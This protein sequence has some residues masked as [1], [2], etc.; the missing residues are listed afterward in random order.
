MN[1]FSLT[2]KW[3]ENLPKGQ[4]FTNKQE[5]PLYHTA[6]IHTIVQRITCNSK[7]YRVFLRN[8]PPT[9]SRNWSK[10]LRVTENCIWAT[11]PGKIRVILILKPFLRRKWKGIGF[12]LWRFQVSV[13]EVAAYAVNLPFAVSVTD[14]SFRV[15]EQESDGESPRLLKLDIP[16]SKLC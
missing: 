7:D 8:M 5:I 9:H 15:L 12:L 4:V 10:L 14:N 1:E 2:C 11:H 6:N 13:A 3:L 16:P